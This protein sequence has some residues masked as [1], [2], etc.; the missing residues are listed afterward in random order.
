VGD[1]AFDAID[2]LFWTEH[3]PC[4]WKPRTRDLA[5]ALGLDHDRLCA[6]CAVL[7]AM[8]AASEA[9]RGGSVEHVRG[10]LALRPRDW[11]ERRVKRARHSRRGRGAQGR[12]SP[13]RARWAGTATRRAQNARAAAKRKRADY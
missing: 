3:D 4:A 6:W 7:A 13:A 8:L 5:A 9:T 11:A 1:S 10:L 12:T 2:R